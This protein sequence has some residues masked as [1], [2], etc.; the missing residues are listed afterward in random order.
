MKNGQD[1]RL[2]VFDVDG[3]LTD[4]EAKPLDLEL[5]RVLA[6][7]NRRARTEGSPGVTLCT[8]RPQPYVEA[9]MQAMDCLLPAIFE[10]GAGCFVPGT[11]RSYPHPGIGDF[12]VIREARERLAREA[13]RT[14]RIFLQPGKEY[15]VS[16]FPA[17]PADRDD[18]KALI[19]EVVG[20]LQDRLESAYSASCLNIH[21]R[22]S[23]KGSGME[24]LTELTGVP[25]ENILGVGDSEVDLPF[26]ERTGYA[27]APSNASPAVKSLCGYVSPFPTSGGARDILRRYGLDPAAEGSG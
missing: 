5:M 6:E 15:T 3:V 12:S 11:G 16:V 4:G 21:P 18:L 27:A 2:I 7:L 1:I 13:E 22:G 25:P 24:L 17:D 14:G 26:L 10:G 8:G 9:L 20:D 19:S 23:N